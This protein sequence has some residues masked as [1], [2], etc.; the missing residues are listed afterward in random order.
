MNTTQKGDIARVFTDPTTKYWFEG[1]AMLMD[2]IDSIGGLE[3]WIVVFL[4]DL[5]VEK[6]FISF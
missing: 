3:Y 5:R 2:K 4:T 6:R 1:E